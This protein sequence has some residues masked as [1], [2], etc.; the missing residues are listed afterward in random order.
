VVS[1]RFFSDSISALRVVFSRFRTAGEGSEPVGIRKKE[2][3]SSSPS[4]PGTLRQ[5]KELS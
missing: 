2:P 1:S 4:W 5:S 3:E